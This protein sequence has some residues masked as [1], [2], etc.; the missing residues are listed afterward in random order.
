MN[1]EEMAEII[2]GYTDALI[3]AQHIV[4]KESDLPYEKSRIGEVLLKAYHESN[5]TEEKEV[6]EEAFLK[7]ESFL[8]DDDFNVVSKYLML[9]G[10]LRESEETQER[11]FEMAAEK[12]PTTAREVLDIFNKVEEKLK[13][14]RT[15]L[16]SL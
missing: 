15:Q 6:L 14:R 12:V 4:G 2:E 8:E 11:L 16:Q 10:E 7:L 5:D 9:L 1:E 13:Y 3:N